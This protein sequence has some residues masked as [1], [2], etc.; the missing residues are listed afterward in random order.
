MWQLDQRRDHRWSDAG[1]RRSPG[2][3]RG[4]DVVERGTHVARLL[5]AE[6]R[7]DRRQ[8]LLLLLRQLMA[9]RRNKSS[10]TERRLLVVLLFL[11][12][13]AAFLTTASQHGPLPDEE[14]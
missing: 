8:R 1:P 5:A 12:S 3:R 14:P 6:P 4:R 7:A 9:Q 13:P 11:L 10:A 2:R